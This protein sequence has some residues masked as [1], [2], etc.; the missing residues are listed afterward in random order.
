MAAGTWGGSSVG[1]AQHT[2]I[3][4]PLSLAPFHSPHR[5]HVRHLPVSARLVSK[6]RLDRGFADPPVHR[7][8]LPHKIALFVPERRMT[9][10]FYRRCIDLRASDRKLH[11]LYGGAGI[12]ESV[13]IF[14]QSRGLL[15]IRSRV[16]TDGQT[17][18]NAGDGPPPFGCTPCSAPPPTSPHIRP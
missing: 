17:A 15:A 16:L 4:D 1:F 13:E 6:G 11:R 3:H 14:L 10:Q 8:H 2:S 12:P 7:F 5:P 18:H 9:Q